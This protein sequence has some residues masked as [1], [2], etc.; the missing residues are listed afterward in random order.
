[1]ITYVHPVAVFGS[2]SVRTFEAGTHKM[3]GSE[4]NMKDSLGPEECKNVS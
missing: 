2:T 3:S 4:R 1:L